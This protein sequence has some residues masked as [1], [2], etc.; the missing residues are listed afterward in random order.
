[1]E[2]YSD[3]IRRTEPRMKLCPYCGGKG[4]FRYDLEA[5]YTETEPCAYCDG[6]GYVEDDNRPDPDERHDE[7]KVEAFIRW[8]QGKIM[9]Y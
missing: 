1:M 6:T 3:Y 4:V 7:R 5:G 8:Q 2:T 9:D